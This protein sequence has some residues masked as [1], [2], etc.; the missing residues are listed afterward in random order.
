MIN[1]N[2]I[3]HGVINVREESV[4]QKLSMVGITPETLKILKEQSSLFKEHA[5][6]IVDE[7]YKKIIMIPHL[8]NIISKH[9]TLERLKKTQKEYFLSLTNG[10]IDDIYISNRR[11]VGKVH[12]RIRLEPEW[13]LGAYQVY[14]K[15]VIPLLTKKYEGDPKLPEVLLA[16]TRITSFDM[17]LVEE[18]YLES[19]TSKMLKFDDIKILEKKLLDTSE[20]L[21]ANAEETSSSVEAMYASSEEIAAAS[22]EAAT[23]AGQV[24]SMA[25]HSKEVVNYTLSQIHD[26][27]NQMLQLQEST[28]RINE[29]SK[30]IEEIIS[31]IQGISKQTNILSLNAT[32]E[33]ARAGEYGKGFAVVAN[34]V[35]NLAERTHKALEEIGH[36]VNKSNTAVGEMITVVD[37]TN[38]SVVKGSKHTSELYQ[39]LEQMMTGISSNLEQVTTVTKQ[40]KGFA[41]MSEQIT[42]SSQEVAELAEKLHLVGEDLSDRLK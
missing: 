31:L 3:Y 20:T 38:S 18:T 24:Q 1:E 37:N 9:S 41:E 2:S 7:F 8:K 25:M 10:I 19:Y 21:V 33:A 4:K 30:K 13:F 39:V 14:Y 29:T 22:E 12:D 26:I 17:Q 28:T 36:L 34:E 32:I 6:Q 23:H 11:K 42:N 15:S 16:Y 27:E 40:V 35:K 5:E